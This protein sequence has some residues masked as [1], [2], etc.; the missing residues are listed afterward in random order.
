M[1]P[2]K[3]ID[4]LEEHKIIPERQV[5]LLRKRAQRAEAKR[6]PEPEPI[7]EKHRRI[8]LPALWSSIVLIAALAIDTRFDVV[9][10]VLSLW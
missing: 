8:Q 4:A 5:E 9:S 6:V 1:D 10:M 2:L 7:P 3:A